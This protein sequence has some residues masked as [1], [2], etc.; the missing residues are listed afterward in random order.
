MG[1]GKREREKHTGKT[2]CRAERTSGQACHSLE[3]LGV[4][5]GFGCLEVSTSLILDWRFWTYSFR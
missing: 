5:S 2:P 1:G 4:L 3:G